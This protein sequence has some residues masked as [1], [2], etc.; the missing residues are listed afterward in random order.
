MRSQNALWSAEAITDSAANP[1]E[2]YAYDAYGS[3]SITD[4]LGVAVPPNSWGTPNSAIGN[5]YLFTGRQLDE[6]TGLFDYRARYYGCVEGRFLGRDLVAFRMEQTIDS[7]SISGDQDSLRI[8]PVSLRNLYEYASG[9]PVN[10]L[11][12]SGEIDWDSA[13]YSGTMIGKGLNGGFYYKVETEAGHKFIAWKALPSVPNP[14]NFWCHGFTFGGYDAAGGPFSP[15]SGDENDRVGIIIRDE[16]K[17]IPCC[18]AN[19]GDIAVWSPGRKHSAIFTDVVLNK[20]N[21]KRLDQNL[22]MLDT[23]NGRLGPPPDIANMSLKAINNTDNY[24]DD[25]R[26]YTTKPKK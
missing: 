2:R 25:Y 8:Y 3:P 6:E 9:N 22:T 18:Q 5:P 16:W 19:A 26:C 13:K 15:F 20:K 10:R 14:R 23:K 4:G 17:R 11:D 21:N 7:L 1:V 12:P 24:G